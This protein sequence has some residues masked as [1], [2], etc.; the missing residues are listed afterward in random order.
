MKNE[1]RVLSA[2]AASIIAVCIASLAA[3]ACAQGGLQSGGLPVLFICLGTT[4][5]L[6]W[7]IFIP[8]FIWQTELYYDLTG[9]ITT[10]AIIGIAF[11]FKSNLPGSDV[12]A[13]SVILV[14]LVTAW[15]LRLG[16]FLFM[17]I[18]RAGEDRRFRKWKKSFPLFFRTWTLQG[19][20]IF[21]TCLAALSAVTSVQRTEVDLSLYLGLVLWI[22]GFM[23]EVMAD[24]QKTRFRA[25]KKNKD[26]FI[27]SGLWA[28]SRHPNY[29]G[30]IILWLGI[31]V[32][33]LPAVRGWQY[34]SL[35]SPL[36]VYLLIAKV[37]GIPILE[38]QADKKWGRKKGYQLYKKRTPVLFPKL[39]NA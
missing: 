4:F 5:L 29:F 10:L 7:L 17:R 15:T 22:C 1:S 20:W 39:S 34:V 28:L 26:K 35:L 27:Q 16:A 32:I 3:L 12:D 9:S 19:L 21:F 23:I 38:A 24:L 11:Y 31:V 37:S 18:H 30:E 2:C 36:F 33:A 25:E 14:A 6:Q 13:R 8:S